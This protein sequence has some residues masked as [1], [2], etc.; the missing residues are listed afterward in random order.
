MQASIPEEWKRDVCVILRAGTSIDVKFTTALQPWQ[1]AFPNDT[2]FDLYDALMEA[3]SPE[4][5]FGRCITDMDEPGETW[6]FTFRRDSRDF[7]GKICLCPSRKAIIV[8][9]AHIS[10]KGNKL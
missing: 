5:V 9:S 6:T 4:I 7:F 8:Y 2:R 1:D 10:L 3:L